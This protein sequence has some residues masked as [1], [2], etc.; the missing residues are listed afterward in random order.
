[1]AQVAPGD[2]HTAP[3]AKIVY[4]APFNEKNQYLVRVT[5]LGAHRIGWAIKTTNAKRLNVNPPAGCLDAK[6]AVL[7]QVSC[8][9][10]Q[11]EN[12][13]TN[14]DRITVEWTNAPA[15]AAQ[16]FRREWFQSDGIVRRK[17][18]PIEYNP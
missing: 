15:G 12:E 14:N 13:D 17:N 8:E 16:Q 9:P 6:E 1:M 4:N 18:L 7:L 2:I 10:F 5:N 11:Y 3:N